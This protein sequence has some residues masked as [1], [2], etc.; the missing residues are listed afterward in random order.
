MNSKNTDWI[1]F[2]V[3]FLYGLT[4]GIFFAF[5]IED[6]K[7]DK[8]VKK[9][10]ENWV[11]LMQRINDSYKIDLPQPDTVTIVRIDTLLVR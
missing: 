6:R 11:V 9:Q 4:V 1:P 2:F 3:V 10:N 5:L 8:A 7:I